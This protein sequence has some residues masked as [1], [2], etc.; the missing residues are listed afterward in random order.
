M[1]LK[2]TKK[3]G[4]LW[5]MGRMLGVQVRRSTQLPVGYEREAEKMRLDIERE[6]IEGKFQTKTQKHTFKDAVDSYLAWKHMEKYD[7][8]TISAH[9]EMLS[10]M[11]G[12]VAVEDI[13]ADMV[14]TRTSKPWQH[15]KPGSVRRYL[16]TMSAVLNHASDRWSF[17]AA[18]IKKPSVDDARDAHFTAEEANQFL[19][20]VREKHPHYEPHFT[21]LI[22]CGVRLNELLRLTKRDFAGSVL[23]MQRRAVGNGKTETRVIPLTAAVRNLMVGMTPWGPMF[24]K[25]SGEP[26]SSSNDASNYLGKVLKQGCAELGFPAMRV[27]DLRHTFAYLV[28]QAG[29]DVADLQTLLGHEDI[30]QTMRYRGFV[31]SRAKQFVTNARE[32]EMHTQPTG[33]HGIARDSGSPGRIRTAGQAISDTS[34]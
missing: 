27:H 11:F 9:C 10:G 6:I 5:V 30:S 14:Q 15:L 7:T 26:W 28:A 34:E 3:G 13:T 2:I 29:A 21:V 17:K 18:K 4:R 25:P 1:P 32:Q 12:D 22:D 33:T 23:R 31:L 20:W 16:N 19:S 8:K 24:V